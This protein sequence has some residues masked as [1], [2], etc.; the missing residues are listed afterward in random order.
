MPQGSILGPLLFI[1]YVNDL[2]KALN[3]ADCILF[4]D[5][6]NIFAKHKTSEQ[7]VDIVNSE[8]NS[9]SKWLASNKLTLNITKT[10]FMIFHRAKLKRHQKNNITINIANE[11]I[12]EAKSTKFLG[13]IIDQSLTWIDH[14]NYVQNK[15]AKGSHIICKAKPL[16]NTHY[17]RQLYHTF[18]YPYLIYCVEIWGNSKKIYL[19]RL[20]K[21]QK[22]IIRIITHSKPR[23]ESKDLFKKVDILPFSTLVCYRIGILMFKLSLGLLPKNINDLFQTNENIHAYNTRNKNKLYINKGNHEFV[24]STFVYQGTNLWNHILQNINTIV[25]FRTFKINLKI[26]LVNSQSNFR[27]TS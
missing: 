18:I 15:I 25:S 13:V 17:L 23:T 10:H 27:Y 21:T 24:Y 12:M 7:V 9:L 19:D 2:H 14:I 11:H 1:L 6:T 26:F 4:A 8:L 3:K 5:D 16:V 22:R 20:I